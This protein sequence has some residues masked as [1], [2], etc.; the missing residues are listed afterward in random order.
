MDTLSNPP[1]PADDAATFAMLQ[2]LAATNPKLREMMAKL[3]V[4]GQRTIL[5]IPYWSV[6]EWSATPAAGAITIG[7]ERRAFFQYQQGQDMSVAGAA[8]RIATYADTNLQ[9]A[10]ETLSNAD[11][12][13]YGICLEIEPGSEPLILQALFA[14]SFLDIS[15]DGQNSIRIGTPAMFPSAGGM[16]GEGQ[17]N[18][19]LPSVNLS[20]QLD[21]GPGQPYGFLSN[22]NP[23]AGSF[24]RFPE[25]FIWGGL[26]QGGADASL[27]IGM[28]LT[29]ATT[30]T[31]P[32]ARAAGAAGVAPG[33]YTPPTALRDPGTFARI[34]CRLVSK[35]V[36]R[37]SKNA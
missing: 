22:G 6:A 26:G 4:D 24:L 3:S 29:R 12:Y 18:A 10:G 14:D 9:R 13:I 17:S 1:N 16:Y 27:S 25:P 34:R 11:V 19:V 31:F 23:I 15:T 37:R 33:A 35:S 36:N 8:G 21:A 20:G 7:T 30:I 2:Q 28:T 5:P 32:A